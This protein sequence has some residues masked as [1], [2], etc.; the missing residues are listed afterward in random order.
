MDDGGIPG[1]SLD[2]LDEIASE[3]ESP[4]FEAEHYDASAT[5]HLIEGRFVMRW[6]AMEGSMSGIQVLEVNSIDAAMD[7]ANFKASELASDAGT[8]FDKYLGLDNI[9]IDPPIQVPEHAERVGSKVLYDSYSEDDLST[10]IIY[11]SVESGVAAYLVTTETGVVIGEYNS[12]EEIDEAIDEPT[13]FSV[14]DR[15]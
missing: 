3:D 6:S 11:R 4:A 8:Y 1:Y 14:D 10:L 9:R 15:D 5:I 2:E 12:I 7:E 13:A